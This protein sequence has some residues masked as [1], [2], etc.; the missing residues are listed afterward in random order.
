MS[1]GCEILKFYSS[2]SSEEAAAIMDPVPAKYSTYFN[3]L[4]KKTPFTLPEPKTSPHITKKP[5]FDKP[6][7]K[8][9]PQGPIKEIGST[10]KVLSVKKYLLEETTKELVIP[11]L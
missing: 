10:V 8:R 4:I 3:N 5:K 2:S 6:I 9:P 1:S 11:N 7:P